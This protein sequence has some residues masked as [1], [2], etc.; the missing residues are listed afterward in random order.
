M[1]VRRGASQILFRLLPQQT[2]DFES[3]VWK[4][5]RW[6][7]PIPLR[8]DQQ[9]LRSALLRS[10]TP[11]STVDRDSRMAEDLL[12]GAEI[13]V[14]QLNRER[15]VVVDQYP[16]IWR[17]RECA[18]VRYD[19]DKTCVCGSSH[20]AQLHF[21]AYHECGAMDQP[22]LPKCREHDQARM[23]RPGT[24][25]ASEIQFDCPVCGRA[26]GSGLVRRQ[27][28]CGSGA[29]QVNVHRAST[30]YTP[31]FTVLV[32]PPDPAAAA[33]LRA[34]GGGARA[35]EWILRG[36]PADGVSSD[37]QTYSGLFQSLVGQGLPEASAREMAELAVEK[38]DVR[39]DRSG[40][41]QAID[42]PSGIRNDAQEEA[43]SL[44]SAVDEGR[45][46]V[47][48]LKDD[49]SPPL[50]S[51]YSD[52]ERAFD[53]AGLE[54]VDLLPA[55]PV[56]TVAYGYTRGGVRP[57]D[58]RLV[59]F[60]NNTNQLR[61]YGQLT[62]TEALLFRLDPLKVHQWLR[63]RGHLE[64]RPDD[65]REARLAIMR[66]S[67]LPE[68]GEDSDGHSLGED[69]LNLVH[70][71]AHRSIRHLAAFAGIERNGLAEYLLPRHLCFIVYAASRGD[72][73]LGGLQAVFETELADYL[74]EAVFGE[75]RCPLDPGCKSGGGACMACLH[76]G[77]P[78]CRWFNRHLSRDYLFGENGFLR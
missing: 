16:E 8:L 64:G 70:S 20:L 12:K 58:S 6:E 26:L 3:R 53:A 71:I 39:D 33:K 10:I 22:I 75:S 32:N 76:L 2:A 11:W 30:V 35:L 41:E 72:F 28:R 14:V 17:C 65:E 34:G 78:S 31:R 36:M 5:E 68:P 69:V 77:E 24:A 51:L 40:D 59:P 47:Q 48:D 44:A 37:G 74:D 27:C 56:A 38:G 13:D 4:V 73:V 67:R 21:V 1:R 61:A 19:A 25:T 42:L 23:K 54:S 50:R 15:G 63:D 29:M 9:A 55:F 43:L 57:G 46:T 7:D 49:A 62:Q 66:R 60:R 18:R 45:V 52:Y